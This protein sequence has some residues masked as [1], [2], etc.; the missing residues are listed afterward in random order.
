MCWIFFKKFL[1][2]LVRL[3]IVIYQSEVQPPID[4]VADHIDRLR[5]LDD[6][7][8]IESKK[9]KKNLSDA[10]GEGCCRDVAGVAD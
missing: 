5:L 9:N 4:A 8:K 7:H 10:M 2:N 6:V 1:F 3:A